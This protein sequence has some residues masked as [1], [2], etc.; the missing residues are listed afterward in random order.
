MSVRVTSELGFMRV[1]A[2]VV[3]VSHNILGLIPNKGTFPLSTTKTGQISSTPGAAQTDAKR[4]VRG[5]GTLFR[6]EVFE[7][8]YIYAGDVVRKVTDVVS[9]TMLYVEYP[10]PANV[11]AAALKTC[12]AGKYKIIRA[13]NTAP[14]DNAIYNEAKLEQDKLSERWNDMGLAP[15]SYDVSG[16]A[17]EITFDISE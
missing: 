15:V 10:F 11:T 2:N 5:T 4:V 7:G 8:D 3:P 12:K 9:D 6:T 13:V 14:N 1:I 17:A 16:A